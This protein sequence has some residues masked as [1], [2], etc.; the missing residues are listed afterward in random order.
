MIK[1][2]IILA[3]GKGTRLQS[4][5]GNKYP[6]PLVPLNGISL[7]EYSINALIKTGVKRILIGCG[8]QIEQFQYLS[9]KYD[10]VSIT[11]NSYYDSRSSLYTFLLFENLVKEPFYLLEADILYD[12]KILEVIGKYGEKQNVILTSKP[13]ELDDN[14]YF[15][16]DAGRLLEI[17]KKM[18]PKISDGI[19]TGIWKFSEGFIQRFKDYCNSIQ[20]DFSEDYEEVLANY[21]KAEEAI[22]IFHDE[23]LNWCEIDNSDHLNY[24]LTHVLPSIA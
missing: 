19:M 9:E 24:A 13:L 14:V 18:D 16:S 7:I 2:A 12:P 3:A 8:H 6:K 1:A 22:S 17:G 5:T 4:V 23:N 20:V 10:E 15:K 21:S 11:N